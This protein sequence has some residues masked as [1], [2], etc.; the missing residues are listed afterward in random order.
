MNRIHS[1]GDRVSEENVTSEPHLAYYTIDGKI[2]EKPKKPVYQGHDELWSFVINMM[3]C[4]D[5]CLFKMKQYFL[6]S[7]L[8]FRACKMI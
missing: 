5:L 2:P 1:K 4:L 3:L 7:L 8:A 6:Q